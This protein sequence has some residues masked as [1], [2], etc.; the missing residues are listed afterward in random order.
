MI[1]GRSDRR[2]T[3]ILAAVEPNYLGRGGR[4]GKKEGRRKLW[5]SLALMRR[6]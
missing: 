4:E 2:D 1:P 6:H 5:Q 3:R